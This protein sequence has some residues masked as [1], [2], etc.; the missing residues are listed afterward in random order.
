MD[1]KCAHR[2]PRD[3]QSGQAVVEAAIILPA[4]IFLLLCAI[5]ITLLQQ[6]RLA[7]EY[8]AF[9]AARA[10]VV[11]NGN[12]APMEQAATWAVLPTFGRA[13][14][15]T[16]LTKTM[17][18]FQA[19]EQVLKAVNLQQITVA[20]L[21]P[22]KAD[23]A[24]QSHLQGR[25]IDFDDVRPDVSRATLL[26]LQVRYLY[27][28]RVPFANKMVQSI[29]MATHVLA[30]NAMLERWGGHDWTAP[31]VGGG[32]TG[33]DGTDAHDATR[34]LALGRGTIPDGTPGGLNMSGLAALAGAG[35]PLYFLPVNAWFTLRMQS[36]PFLKWAAP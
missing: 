17:A 3:G 19:Q 6:A 12:P 34:A 5:Q 4:M 30:N 23:F 1:R 10:G 14:S 32:V 7:T 18:R 22:R 13:D 33:D 31:K 16:E 36:N 15:M 8:A 29:W 24:Q 2:P 21:N 9:T 20:V 11:M 35:Q 27:Q 28:L 25:E 26:S